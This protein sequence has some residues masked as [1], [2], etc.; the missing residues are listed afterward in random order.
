MGG[1]KFD[2]T[3]NVGTILAILLPLLSG[4]AFLLD[5]FNTLKDVVVDQKAM[6][7]EIVEIQK[8]LEVN[9]Q[10]TLENRRVYLEGEKRGR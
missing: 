3:V 7:G 1:L 5:Q 2:G 8:Q 6:R 9:R 10:E 4:F